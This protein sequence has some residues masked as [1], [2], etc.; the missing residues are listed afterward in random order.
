MVSHLVNLVIIFPNPVGYS[1]CGSQTLCRVTKIGILN[2]TSDSFYEGSRT[3]GVQFVER[4]KKMLE[5]ENVSIN[6]VA[7]SCGFSDQSY[8]SKVFS[9]AYGITPTEHR[10]EK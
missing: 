9:S 2:L 5:N 10:R 1:F 6:E 3:C 4:A 8:F 7:L